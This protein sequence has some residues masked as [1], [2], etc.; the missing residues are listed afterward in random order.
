[1]DTVYTSAESVSQTAIS[2]EE[3]TTALRSISARKVVV[4]LDCCHAAGIGRPKGS[5]AQAIKTISDSY[6]DKLAKG[7]GRVILASSRSTESSFVMPEDDNSLFTKH[8]LA[9]LRGGIPSDDG[10]IRIFDLFEYLQPRVTGDQ[11]NQHPIFKAELEDNFPVC[12]YLGGK[13]GVISK[14]KQGFRYDAFVSYVDREPDVTWVW[15]TLVPL[16]EKYDLRIAVS[17][18]VGEPGVARVVNIERG[19][20]QAKRTIIVLSEAYMLDYIADFESTLAQSIGIQE[21]AYRILPVKF[22]AFD[23]DELPSRLKM[24]TTLNLTRP[25]RIEREFDRLVRALQSPLPRR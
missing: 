17:G 2:D 9:G 1:V 14:D 5:N 6:Y 3:F 23:E 21:G 22:E 11:A 13:I 8:L 20:K 4:V 16:L 24:L 25:S 12:L 18:D 10:M 7:R 15:D 19:I